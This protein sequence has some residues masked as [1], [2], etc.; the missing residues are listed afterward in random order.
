MIKRYLKGVAWM[1]LTFSTGAYFNIKGFC[2]LDYASDMNRRRSITGFV[3]IVG[4]N[5]MS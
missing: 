4:G 5:T 3:F 1:S 2:D